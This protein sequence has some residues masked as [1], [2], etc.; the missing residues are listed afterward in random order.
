VA[1]PLTACNY[2]N[3][4][5]AML[6]LT[7]ETNGGFAYVSPNAGDNHLNIAYLN[8]WKHEANL[9]TDPE[10][11]V[12]CDVEQIGTELKLIVGD[13]VAHEP[14]TKPVPPTR[15]FNLDKAI[16]RFP[17]V[18]AANQPLT[19][20]R[21]KFT[22]PPTE[23]ANPDD[24]KE[25]KKNLKWI[26]S[27]K[28]YH[29]GNVSSTTI[30]PDWPD[31]VN[32][33]MEL[34]GGEIVA[35]TPAI[36]IYKK[37]HL[38]FRQR[39]VSKHKVSATD[40]SIYTIKIPISDLPGGNLEITLS[41]ATSGFTKLVIKPQGNKVELQLTGLHA[42]GAPD[43]ND[44]DP[45]RDFCA[46]YQL[47]QPMP[48]AKDFLVPHFMKATLAASTAPNTNALPYGKPSPGIFCV[49]DWF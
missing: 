49:P 11:E 47:L 31:V 17:A 48:D 33:R 6:T 20:V 8:S 5:S 13:I 25:W 45:L 36:P 19:M 22:D 26:P 21:D 18:E 27:I 38:D 32:G 35:T 4:R 16:V 37:A 3:S 39:G 14:S 44:G 1:I 15:E 29:A 43:L 7:I 34:R 10:L 9:D 28:E 40:K 23:P 30:R 2:F 42:M 41:N 24:P 12:A 46:F